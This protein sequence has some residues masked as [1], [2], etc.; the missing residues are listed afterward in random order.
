ME[1]SIALDSPFNLDYTL[2]SGQVFRWERRGDWWRGM[3]SG[4]VL[5]LRQEGDSLRCATS[6]EALGSEFVRS[7]FRLE[8]DFEGVLAS[9]SRDK[10]ITRSVQKFYGLRL[11]RQERWECL[12]SF[13]LATNANIPRIKKMVSSICEKYG[14]PFEFEGEVGHVFPWPGALATATIADLKSCGLGYRG[15]FLKHVAGAI[16]Q[17]RI[18]FG[19]LASLGYSEARR[20]L[21]AKLFGEKVLLGVGPKVADCVLL[22]S[23]GQDSAF[24]IDVWIAR[25]LARSYPRLF[26][27]DLRRKLSVEG[28]AR[29]TLRDYDRV[30][31]SARKHF[32]SYAGYAQ[33]YLYMAARSAR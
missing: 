18:N 1:Y 15:A 10:M 23:L 25:E 22:Y 30:S 33:Q 28:K 32:G 6:S 16:D 9:F 19:E 21:L 20:D 31:E 13:L 27:R 2:E 14:E 12:A 8:E 7:Y 26:A 4:G 17:G 11:I 3:V 29:L 5:S 24:P